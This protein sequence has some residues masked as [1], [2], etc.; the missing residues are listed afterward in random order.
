MENEKRF[1]LRYGGNASRRQKNSSGQATHVY[2]YV[3]PGCEKTERFLY[4]RVETAMDIHDDLDMPLGKIQIR[5]GGGTGGH[6]GLESI[7][8][9]LK[10]NEFG[11]I[12][13]GIRGHELRQEHAQTGIDTNSFVMGRFIPKE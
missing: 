12:R 1:G 8:E 6:H 4:Q 3:G 2:E 5:R 9:H 7:V 11:R 10:T 13:I